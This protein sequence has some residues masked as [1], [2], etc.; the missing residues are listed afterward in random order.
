M[1]KALKH[2]D[3]LSLL[4]K[5]KSKKRRHLLI[6]LANTA[7]IK[8]IAECILNILSGN[9]RLKSNQK[10]KLK[11]YRSALR[12]VA[13]KHY[14]TKQKKYILRQKGGFLPALLPL[15][16]SALTSIVPALFGK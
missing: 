3:Y 16:I 8:A 4:S 1:S 5:S 7:E 9:I 14:S 11:R 2:K 13:N 15:A 10:K 12:D 6:D